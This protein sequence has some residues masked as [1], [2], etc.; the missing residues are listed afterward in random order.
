MRSSAAEVILADLA[1]S[2]W[3][4]LTAVQAQRLGVSRPRL[5]R[6]TA[7]GN[8]VRLT[9]GVYALRGSMWT[10]HVGLR[11]AW[12][13]LDPT[14]LA[15]DRLDDGAGGAVVSHT[16]AAALHD[17]GDLAADRHEFTLPVRKQTRRPELRLHRARLPD[18]D[19]TRGDGLPVTT[20]LRTVVD[21]VGDGHDGGHV[22][23]VLADA[24]RTRQ[25]DLSHLESRLAPFAARFGLTGH[26]GRGVVRHLLELGGV[27]EQADADMIAEVARAVRVPVIDLLG[28]VA[29]ASGVVRPESPVRELVERLRDAQS[30]PKRR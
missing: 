18:E 5:V 22:A 3:G 2:Q 10:S 26:D 16:S 12:L 13:A 19:V 27:T 21:L 15:A 9:H 24:V 7:A 8:L 20:P 4:L 14:R 29:T 17:L 1:A 30:G 23:D 11:A 6:L 28:T 25:I